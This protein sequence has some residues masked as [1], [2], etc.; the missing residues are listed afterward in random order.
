MQAYS[1][2]QHS[3][4]IPAILL[5][6]LVIM[7]GSLF[8]MPHTVDPGPAVLPVMLVI[9]AAAL[10]AMLSRLTTKVDEGGVSWA[11]GVG[12]PS[13]E[14]AAGSIARAEITQTNFMEG[15][16]IHWTIWHGWV[17]NVWGFQA[18]QIFK[19]D[20]TSITIGTDDPEGFVAAINAAKV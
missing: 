12:F 11:F 19:N 17:W 20:G 3:P 14:I 13:G 16:G 1:H 10:V 18:V 5:L 9:V 2:R 4:I 15:W 7:M 6:M 8:A